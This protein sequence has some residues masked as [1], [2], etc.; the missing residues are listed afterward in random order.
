MYLNKEMRKRKELNKI[1][2]SRRMMLPVRD[3]QVKMV[4]CFDGLV[5]NISPHRSQWYIQVAVWSGYQIRGEV[6]DLRRLSTKPVIINLG[7][8]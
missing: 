7:I 1:Q 3:H 5:F 2:D 4:W 6:G 8:R